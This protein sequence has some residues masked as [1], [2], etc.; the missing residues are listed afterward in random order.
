MILVP[1]FYNRRRSGEDYELFPSDDESSKPKFSSLSPDGS[2]GS[3]NG[4]FYHQMGFAFQIV[5]TFVPT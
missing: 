4:Q 1:M 3:Q 2:N 5:S